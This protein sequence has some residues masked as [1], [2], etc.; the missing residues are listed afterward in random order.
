MKIKLMPAYIG[1]DY[2]Y[3]TKPYLMLQLKEY[4]NADSSLFYMYYL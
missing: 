2:I 1:N 4:S 3:W